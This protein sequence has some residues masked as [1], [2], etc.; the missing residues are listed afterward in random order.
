MSLLG[1]ATF[2]K[3]LETD[4]DSYLLEFSAAGK[5]VMMGWRVTGNSPLPQVG[6]I[7]KAWGISGEQLQRYALTPSPTYY[8]LAE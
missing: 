5:R 7:E 3:R 6:A 1:S 2:L 8:L 4:E